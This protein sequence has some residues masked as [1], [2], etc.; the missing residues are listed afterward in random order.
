[1]QLAAPGGVSIETTG[2]LEPHEVAEVSALVSAA[3]DS[4]GVRPLSEHVMLHLRYGGDEEVRNVLLHAP[5]GSLAGY[6]H[7]DVTDVVEG[8]SAEL[9][10]H[11]EARGRGYGRALVAALLAQAPPRG[12]R[13]WAHGEHANAA[14]LAVG[15]GFTR[16]RA[17]WQMRR[18]LFAPI[19]AVPLPEGVRVRMFIPGDDDAAWVDLN[20]RAFA[21]HPEQGSWTIDDLHRRLQEPWFDP[22]GFFVAHR[23]GRMVGFHWTKVHGGDGSMAGPHAHEGHV[24]HGHEPIGEV[25]VVGVDPDEQGHGLGKAMTVVGLRHLRALGLP[26]AMLY[27]EEDNTAAIRVYTD[28]GFTHWDTDVMYRWRPDPH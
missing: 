5:D 17:L 19:P 28:L 26:E 21:H 22:A 13:L 3:T 23:D 2:R 20:A 18:S 6:A 1:M 14:R 24:G 10:V 25:Y 9:A 11:P 16:V 12:L 8:G 4:D 7:L 15:M 27:V